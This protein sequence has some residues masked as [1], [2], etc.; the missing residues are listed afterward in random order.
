MALRQDKTTGI[1]QI[2]I[3]IA[4]R[5]RIQRSANT[6]NKAKAKQLHDKIANEAWAEASLGVK[7]KRFWGELVDLW[8]RTKKQE[9]K[10]SLNDDIIKLKWLLPHFQNGRMVIDDV[11]TEFVE[12]VIDKKV[13]EGK[14]YAGRTVVQRKEISAATLNRYRALIYGMLNLAKKRGWLAG[15]VPLAQKAKEKKRPPL[16]LTYEQAEKLIQELP[17]KYKDMAIFSLLTGM[18]QDNVV[19]LKWQEV[20][21]SNATLLIWADDAKGKADIQVPLNKQAVDLVSTRLKASNKHPIYVFPNP[22]TQEPFIYPAGKAFKSACKRAG[23]PAG[24]RWHDLRHTWASWHVQNGTPLQVLKELGGWKSLDMV[25]IYAH[26]APS[27]L[28]HYS[29][30]AM[31]LAAPAN[32]AL[33][34]SAKNETPKLAGL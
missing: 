33:P 6:T 19:Q 20:N 10:R 4:G 30:N 11:T 1:W 13:K 2:D 29:G 12:S 26:F 14:V 31:M 23:L 18:R 9:D 5:P 21:V 16:F 34:P 17:E 7:P 15:D 32:E 8:V 24:F 28:S 22:E 3:T 25:L 27:H